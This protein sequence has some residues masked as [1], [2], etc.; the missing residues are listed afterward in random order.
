MTTTEPQT[1]APLEPHDPEARAPGRS[2]PRLPPGFG[3]SLPAHSQPA[4]LRFHLLGVAEGEAPAAGAPLALWAEPA[5]GAAAEPPE[6]FR[7]VVGRY[8]TELAAARREALARLIAEAGDLRRQ[9]SEL[10]AA[11]A[12]HARA[13]PSAADLARSVGEPAHG[14]IDVVGLAAHLPRERGPKHLPPERRGRLEASLQA[15]TELAPEPGAACVHAV[16]PVHLSGVAEVSAGVAV[17][18][19]ERG[20]EGGSEPS[21]GVSADYRLA[22]EL[23]DAAMRRRLS[24]ARAM[25]VAR[26]E[27]SAAYRAEVHDVVV[28][29]LEWEMLSDGERRA[30]EAVVVVRQAR[31]RDCLPPIL[32]E[33]RPLHV[34]QQAAAWAAEPLPL[35]APGRPSLASRA[36]AHAS[37]F[38]LQS[39]ACRPEHLW[40]GLARMV[41]TVRPALALVAS[42]DEA[43]PSARGEL[44]LAVLSRHRPL[45]TFDP[46]AP[47]MQWLSFQDN[48]APERA[49][50]WLEV[51][52]R[53]PDGSAHTLRWE[54]T[55]A[56]LV[57]AEEA[58]ASSVRGGAPSASLLPIAED[59]WAAD[60]LSVSEYLE[61]W[62]AGTLRDQLPFVWTLRGDGTVQRAV[63]TR[64][65]AADVRRARRAYR[66]LQQLGG[67]GDPWA[68]R[69]AEQALAAARSEADRD[70]AEREQRHRHELAE[71]RAAGGSDALHRL[72]A[73]LL[74]ED[75]LLAASPGGAAAPPS[76]AQDAGVDGAIGSPAAAAPSATPTPSASFPNGGETA[77]ASVDPRAA[78]TAPAEGLAEGFGLEEPYVETERCTSC[79]EC[80]QRLPDAFRYDENQ[81]AHFVASEKVPYASLVAVA[82]KCP[83]RCIH[84]GAPVEGDETA[85]D[86]LLERARA[87]S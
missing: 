57:A 84:P 32:S 13:A 11:D 18:E 5:A 58:R 28:D 48:P 3:A 76:P 79:N 68:R 8:L 33:G 21:D 14:H 70:R 9:V 53:G 31:S 16:V 6:P 26:L 1:P 66:A 25:R 10:L 35:G 39:S 44:E 71:A 52:C 47:R 15:L 2:V 38:V 87:L 65:L 72:A 45:F 54:A 19:L 30:A 81:Q 56:D 77:P 62:E 37:C 4:L 12:A 42:P 22:C 49:W 41:Q 27:L 40:Q 61:A 34:L 82:E 43:L 29:S 17:V 63:V 64:A 20:R 86:D 73:A 83:A 75:G 7:V 51:G 46:E 59:R 55:L 74:S 78:P 85:T 80:T 36:H 50:P 69:A 24:L 23:A 67:V 60:Q